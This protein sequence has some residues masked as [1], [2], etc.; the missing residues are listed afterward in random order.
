MTADSSSR[1]RFAFGDDAELVLVTPPHDDDGIP[2]DDSVWIDMELTNF[3]GRLMVR[4]RSPRKESDDDNDAAAGTIPASSPPSTTAMP[5]DDEEEETKTTAADTGVATTTSDPPTPVHRNSSTLFVDDGDDDDIEQEGRCYGPADSSLPPPPP[6]LDISA[7]G[8]AVADNASLLSLPAIEE[9]SSQERRNADDDE[10]SLAEQVRRFVAQVDDPNRQQE[11]EEDTVQFTSDAEGSSSSDDQRRGGSRQK[12]TSVRHDGN[13]E[14]SGRGESLGSFTTTDGSDA[15]IMGTSQH[16]ESGGSD[17]GEGPTTRGRAGRRRRGLSKKRRASSLGP[18]GGLGQRASS[19]S[20]TGSGERGPNKEF[21]N[22]AVSLLKKR[23]EGNKRTS[24]KELA[25]SGEQGSS[26]RLDKGGDD[27]ENDKTLGATNN[28]KAYAPS[29]GKVMQVYSAKKHVPATIRQK[30]IEER[31]ASMSQSLGRDPSKSLFPSRL[32]ELCAEP[33]AT[34]AELIECLENNKEAVALKDETGKLPLHILGDN[35]GLVS[36]SQGKQV[37]S[38]FAWKLMEADPEAMV[39][40]DK[41]GH[42]PFVTLIA[43]WV[44]WV[45][46]N[47]KKLRKA[48]QAVSPGLFLRG[49]NNSDQINTNRDANNAAFFARK[50]GDYTSTTRLFPKPEVWDEVRCHRDDIFYYRAFTPQHSHTRI[51][52]L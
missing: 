39:V 16:S 45:Y 23:G 5:T 50:T 47:H 31:R 26:G 32:H 34:L 44:T 14:A 7:Q 41:H 19:P 30:R 10:D 13:N 8:F 43:D 21:F 15:D 35:E 38:A 3:T 25:S 22:R 4:R 24:S 2:D 51:T 40:L 42:M 12:A 29:W 33:D 52:R 20:L 6:S 1:Q 9:M 46:E 18:G 36:S 37:A 11:D 28:K 27:D 17:S 48:K 49:T